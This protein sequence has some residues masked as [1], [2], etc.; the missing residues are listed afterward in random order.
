M[1]MIASTHDPLRLDL[2]KLASD[3]G[4]VEGQWPLA[5]LMRMAETDQAPV[6]QKSGTLVNYRGEAES[7]AV[8]G[9]EPQVWLHLQADAN[10]HLVCQRC[11]SLMEIHLQIERSI[12][13]VGDEEQAAALDADS[14][15]DVLV[16]ERWINLRDLVEDELLMDLPLVPRHG[17]CPVPLTMSAVAEETEVQEVGRPNPFAILAELK[18]KSSPK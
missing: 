17:E 6:E 3:A 15:D 2:A 18:G 11:L 12:R 4:V 5:T 10:I 7:R 14:E 9:G 13:F 8:L 1:H 16:L